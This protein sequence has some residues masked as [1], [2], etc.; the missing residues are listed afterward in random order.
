MPERPANCVAVPICYA[1]YFSFILHLKSFRITWYTSNL[2]Q[3]MPDVPTHRH[4]RQN[5]SSIA[6]SKDNNNLP[7]RA[8]KDASVSLRMISGSAEEK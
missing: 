6:K 4:I 1:K 8:S 5:L 3:T 2:F 7:L